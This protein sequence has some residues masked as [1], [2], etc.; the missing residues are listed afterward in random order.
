MC[1]QQDNEESDDSDAD[2]E[3]VDPLAPP[4]QLIVPA[5]LMIPPQGADDRSIGPAWIENGDESID[6]QGSQDQDSTPVFTIIHASYLLQDGTTCVPVTSC[7]LSQHADFFANQT[8]VPL[9]IIER[10]ELKPFQDPGMEQ[11]TEDITLDHHP[12]GAGFDNLQEA[13][14]ALLQL[15]EADNNPHLLVVLQDLVEASPQ[16]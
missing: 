5:E 9:T 6:S 10:M 15:K 11:G 16:A 12:R 4:V 14:A 8:L 2:D 13:A 7:V 1:N 3:N